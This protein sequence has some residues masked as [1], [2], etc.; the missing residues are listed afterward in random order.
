[1]SQFAIIYV[2]SCRKVI[3]VTYTLQ[4]AVTVLSAFPCFPNFKNYLRLIEISHKRTVFTIITSFYAE[5]DSV[6]SL[7][8][9]YPRHR[10]LW[11]FPYIASKIMTENVND[12]KLVLHSI[13]FISIA[14]ILPH[15]CHSG[16]ARRCCIYLDYIASTTKKPYPMR[17][18]IVKKQILT[19]QKQCIPISLLSQRLELQGTL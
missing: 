16:L 3:K 6:N 9:T 4:D 8:V 12:S 19:I 10:F 18:T 7:T 1:M 17:P 11:R 13:T 14:N 15:F 2:W 5:F